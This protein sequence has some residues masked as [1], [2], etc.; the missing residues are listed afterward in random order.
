MVKTPPCDVQEVNLLWF[1]AL[2]Y[3]V[4]LFCTLLYLRERGHSRTSDSVSV[5]E[6][7]QHLCM[8]VQREAPSNTLHSGGLK[9]YL[10]LN[11]HDFS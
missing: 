3:N 10:F 6:D 11:L 5:C 9:K 8:L 7:G 4:M 2:C 1:P